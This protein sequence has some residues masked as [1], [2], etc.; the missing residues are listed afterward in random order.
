MQFFYKLVYKLKIMNHITK[1]ILTFLCLILVTLLIYHS[2]NLGEEK[3]TNTTQIL[4]NYDLEQ[5]SGYLLDS[6][7]ARFGDESVFYYELEKYRLEFIGNAPVSDSNLLWLVLTDKLIAEET[8]NME[9]SQEEIDEYLEYEMELS[10]MDINQLIDGINNSDQIINQSAKEY[11]YLQNQVN[12]LNTNDSVIKEYYDNFF[13]SEDEVYFWQLIGTEEEMNSAYKMLNNMSW[14]EV[15]NLYPNE[16]T[17]TGFNGKIKISSFDDSIV[18]QINSTKANV[19]TKPF[20]TDLGW[21]IIKHDSDL[22]FDTFKAEFEVDIIVKERESQ[23]V[24]IRNSLINKYQVEFPTK[25]NVSE[26]T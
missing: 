15:F 21:M 8:K 24:Q 19:P 2:V 17:Y 4:E 11:Y 13:L 16:Y 3:N 12:K 6:I 23:I 10:G 9:L 20:E 1:H 26:F 5:E 18:E 22:D 14:Q 7:V 25:L